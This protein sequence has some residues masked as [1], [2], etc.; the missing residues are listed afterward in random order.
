MS[1]KGE[2]GMFFVNL[3]EG[4]NMKKTLLTA[5]A[6]AVAA[7]G[8]NATSLNHT[9]SLSATVPSICSFA[10]GP[11]AT[12][13]G[14]SALQR[15]TSSFT[16]N[17]DPQTA[18]VIPVNGTIKFAQAFCNT[19]SDINLTRTDLKLLG[20]APNGFSNHI[21][22]GATLNWGTTTLTLEVGQANTA[23]VIDAPPSSGDIT[24]E[25]DV[26]EDDRLVPGVYQGTLT[27]N[28]APAS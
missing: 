1:L 17:I 8:A 9:V 26:P 12:G 2:M 6:F 23:T 18:K 27:L 24:L 5:A 13:N 19:N 4:F 28:I 10:T 11:T 15:E 14:F 7:T 21:H 16:I 22:Y 3:A 20:N 25:I